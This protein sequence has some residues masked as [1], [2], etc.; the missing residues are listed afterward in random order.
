MFSH[1]ILHK[2]VFQ[3]MLIG[4][5]PSYGELPF[6]ILYPYLRSNK[7]LQKYFAALDQSLQGME[8]ME[9]YGSKFDKTKH[10]SL[11]L[12]KVSQNNV[13]QPDSCNSV[14]LYLSNN[15]KK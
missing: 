9:I 12:S 13:Y 5:L 1:R 8:V 3:N 4:S 7:S 10:G 2:N 11:F 15:Q 6:K 14:D